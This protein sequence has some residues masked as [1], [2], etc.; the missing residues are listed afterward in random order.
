VGSYINENTTART[1]V[2]AMLFREL[3]IERRPIFILLIHFFFVNI[4]STARMTPIKNAN[5]V[6]LTFV[7]TAIKLSP[8]MISKNNEGISHEK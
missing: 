2:T 1:I 4:A 6:S 7:K 8:L 3:G 5:P